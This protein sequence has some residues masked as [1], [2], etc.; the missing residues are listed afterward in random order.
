MSRFPSSPRRTGTVRCAA[1]VLA[2]A[3]A[4]CCLPLDRRKSR[5]AI[6]AATP[7]PRTQGHR[8]C[9]FS[10]GGA[11]GAAVT[12]GASSSGTSASLRGIGASVLLIETILPPGP[13]AFSGLRRIPPG[14]YE[15]S[16]FVGRN[17]PAK[18][19]AS[20]R[21]PSGGTGRAFIRGSFLRA[22]GCRRPQFQAR[23]EDLAATIRESSSSS[24]TR[25]CA[26]VNRLRSPQ[27]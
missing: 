11:L 15:F 13:S 23:S 17:P 10:A 4:L 9:V 3:A 19:N 20:R 26:C 8:R 21:L 1:L 12:F 2:A 18:S 27:P 22:T 5:T 7:M 6:S 16:R 25:T 24:R 14:G